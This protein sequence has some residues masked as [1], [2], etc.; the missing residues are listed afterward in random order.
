ML[1]RILR[2]A[3]GIVLGIVVQETIG[4]A[5]C[6][7]GDTGS[8]RSATCEYLIPNPPVLGSDTF[9]SD[10]KIFPAPPVFGLLYSHP[11]V[12]LLPPA[13]PS[14]YF[15]P[16]HVPPL[17]PYV[18]PGSSFYSAPAG[19][20][21]GGVMLEGTYTYPSPRGLESP[22]PQPGGITSAVDGVWTNY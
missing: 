1:R 19:G 20:S 4:L 13:L 3:G 6:K 10:P 12:A 22:V 14:W 7:P 18:G 9:Y 17:A 16:L 21:P 8:S 15:K 5:L 2:F 11:G